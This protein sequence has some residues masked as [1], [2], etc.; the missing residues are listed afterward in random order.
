MNKFKTGRLVEPKTQSFNDKVYAESKVSF[1][2]WSFWMGIKAK[3]GAWVYT[4]S[5][6]KISFENW[7][8]FVKSKKP[9]SGD[10]A[11]ASTGGKWIKGR[12]NGN[13]RFVHF[14]CEFV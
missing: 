2:F 14:I 3:R 9:K 7:F 11:S 5:G 13:H 10:C 4:S 1:G 8:K 6:S 12:C